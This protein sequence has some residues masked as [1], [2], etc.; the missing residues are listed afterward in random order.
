MNPNDPRHFFASQEDKD[1]AQRIHDT[2]ALHLVAA[3]DIMDAV[4]KWC[5]FALSDGR[6]DGVLYDEKHHAVAA[7]R[8]HSKDY[9]YLKITPDGI[10]PPDALSYLRTNRHPWIDTTSPVHV[11]NPHIFPHMSNLTPAQRR[12]AKAIAERE[13]RK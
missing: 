13:A 7:M 11:I 9:C 2:V 3:S 12:E 5:V 8:G 4:G 1:A 10:R 6:S